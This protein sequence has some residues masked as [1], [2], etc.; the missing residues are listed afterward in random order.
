MEEQGNIDTTEI[1]SLTASVG[2]VELERT[3]E[4]MVEQ[5]HLQSWKQIYDDC[6]GTGHFIEDGAKLWECMQHSY[7]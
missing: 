4:G 6:A 3:P 2:A 7:A 5:F 1:E